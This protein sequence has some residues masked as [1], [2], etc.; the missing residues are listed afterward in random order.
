MEGHTE[1]EEC[2][3]ECSGHIILECGCGERLILL[4]VENDWRSEE[5]T[6]FECPCGRTLSLADRLNED[7]LEFRRLMRGAFKTTGG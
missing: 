5:R 3:L 1:F 6:D 2:T 4:G 7:V